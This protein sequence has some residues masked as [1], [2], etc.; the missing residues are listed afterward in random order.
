M[1]LLVEVKSSSNSAS[2]T[3]EF[4]GTK[5]DFSPTRLLNFFGSLHI[6]WAMQFFSNSKEVRLFYA[7]HLKFYWSEMKKHVA[8]GADSVVRYI[9][10]M[11]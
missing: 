4:L 9:N 3:S 7:N 8:R 10:G 6:F 11:K 5:D 1:H 2:P